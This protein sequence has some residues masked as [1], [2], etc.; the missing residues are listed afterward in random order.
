MNWKTFLPIV[1]SVLI[2]VA[3]SFFLYQW[4]DKRKTPAEVVQVVK[5]EEAVQIAVAAANLPWGTKIKPEMIKTAPFLKPSLPTGYF[6]STADLKDRVL[7]NP[8]KMNEPITEDKLAPISVK[9]GGVSAILKPGTRAISIKGNK[10]LGISGLVNPGN[11]VD[12]ILTVTDP[13][14]KKIRSKIVLENLLVLATGTEIQKNEKGEPM[15]VDVYTL[16]VTPEQ[17]EKVALAASQGKL[18]FALRGATDSEDIYTKGITIP[19]LL[20]SSSYYEVGTMAPE[21]VQPPEPEKAETTVKPKKVL[22]KRK[23]KPRRSI[24]VEMIKGIE[25]KKKKFLF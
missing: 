9:T 17:S 7:L 4:M 21:K 13:T 25:L 24:T 8:L 15:P 22:K 12:V 3:G 11:R 14:I 10:V 20:A 5:K 16:E 19:Q 18:N 23:W 2:A 6:V 1:V